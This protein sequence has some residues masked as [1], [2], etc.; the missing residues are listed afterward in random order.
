MIDR[1]VLL[2]H[3]PESGERLMSATAVA[4][5]MGVPVA[6]VEQVWDTSVGPACLPA[7]WIKAGKRRSAEARAHT[8]GTSAAIALAYWARKDFGAEIEFDENTREVW[9]VT[10]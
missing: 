3:E 2:V 10:P 4:L 1:R 7:E 5:L 6:E 8:G 9:L